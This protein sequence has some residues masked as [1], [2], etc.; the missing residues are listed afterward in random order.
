MPELPRT[1]LIGTCIPGDD[2]DAGGA[3]RRAFEGP[4]ARLVDLV[5]LRLDRVRAPDTWLPLLLPAAPVPVVATC[6]R[7]DEGRRLALAEPE[8]LAL[9]ARCVDW[10]A[11]WVD[12]EDDVPD[13]AAAEL[14]ERGARLIRSVHLP[15]LP[16]D[17]DARLEELL[18]RPGEAY[19]LIAWEGD[20]ADVARALAA[21]AER[22]GRLVCHVVERPVSRVLGSLVGARFAYASLR[23]HAPFPIP[24]VR[25][26]RREACPERVRPG[27]RAFLLLGSDVEASVSPDLLNAAFSECG[28]DV[29][30]VRWSCADP[31]PALDAVVRFGWLGAAVT[32]PHKLRAREWVRERGGAESAAARSVGAVNTVLTAEDGPRA[33]QTDLGGLLDALSA[34]GLDALDGADA[35]VAGAGGAARAAVRAVE[36]LGGVPHVVAR[37]SEAARDLVQ[38][39]GGSG[40]AYGPGW[41]AGVRPRLV[42]DATPAG[43]PGGAPFLD[44]EAVDAPQLRGAHVLDML[45]AARPTALLAAAE[46]EGAVTVPGFEMLLHQAA[47]QIRS[48]LGVEPPLGVMRR[49]GRAALAA[50]GRAVVLVGLRASG[51]TTLGR[52]LAQVTGRRWID[53]DQVLTDRLGASPD[54][55][56]RSGRLAEFRAAEA[57][58]LAELVGAR[59]VVV[60]TGGGAP[61]HAVFVELASDALVVHLDA[62]DARLLD[63]WTAAPR[64]PLG[65]GEPAE[66]LRHMRA[67]R[68]P[69]FAAHADVR[70]DTGRLS[71]AATLD[72]ILDRL[73]AEEQ[74]PF[75]GSSGTA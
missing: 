40:C 3:I 36:A 34:A 60:S 53:T 31:T 46:R 10:G 64:A 43:P 11:E 30:S 9:L 7:P 54:E 18:S 66:E 63:R 72:A 59:D 75:R 14:V 69:V 48:G 26:W 33:E 62:E 49:A 39:L 12:L 20:D 19:K 58:L 71:A 52:V 42:L 1:Q 23:S 6:R 21:M 68:D 4:A 8:R 13:E 56:I 2:E 55:L 35:V 28:A 29:L 22:P 24:S 47:R 27:H 51:K 57:G 25:R 17:L 44:P 38:E 74:G 41:P 32:T 45:V 15:R 73:D 61:E 5:E 67:T 16:T 70:L 50:A 37:R 65:D